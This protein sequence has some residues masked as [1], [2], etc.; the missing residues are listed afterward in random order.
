MVRERADFPEMVNRFCFNFKVLLHRILPK[1]VV[2]GRRSLKVKCA[3]VAEETPDLLGAC[4][5]EN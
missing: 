2:E 1:P 4:R 3:E 5:A